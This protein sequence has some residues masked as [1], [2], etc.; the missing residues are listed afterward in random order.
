MIKKLKKSHFLAS[1]TKI[2]LL[3]NNKI[4]AQLAKKWDFLWK[5]DGTWKKYR[6]RPFC[7][8]PTSF[9]SAFR[10]QKCFAAWG[11]NVLKLTWIRLCLDRTD[12]N[13]R[14]KLI[15]GFFLLDFISLN[16]ILLHDYTFFFSI[17]YKLL[18]L[19]LFF[20]LLI[21]QCFH[22]F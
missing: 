7:L 13:V 22:L 10:W 14:F 18:K 11:K 17:Y 15:F 4:L 12:V 5:K 19:M 1:R 2:L 21:F 8:G 6:L 20:N 9:T 16:Y 3:S